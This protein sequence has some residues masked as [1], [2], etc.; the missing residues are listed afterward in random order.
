MSA[1]QLRAKQKTFLQNICRLIEFAFK[2]GYELTAGE[3][4]RS[5][6]TQ[7]MHVAA[8][9]SQTMNS[10]HLKRLAADLNIFLHGRL[11][12]SDSTLVNSDLMAAKKL[13]DYWVSLNI[14]NRWGGD[15][16]K[17]GNPLNGAFKDG[18]HF[19]MQDE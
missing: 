17:D 19:E 7:Q 12:F 4:Y 8:G 13:G 1:E 11:L 3:F 10:M 9:R 18:G 2:N 15:F 5:Q 14:K 16:D 6:Q